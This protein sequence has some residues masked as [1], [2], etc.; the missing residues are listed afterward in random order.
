MHEALKLIPSYEAQMLPCRFLQGMKRHISISR[1]FDLWSILSLLE[2]L[3]NKERGSGHPTQSRHGD[4]I[5]STRSALKG[6][7][8]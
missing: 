4:T 3:K 1:P 2:K 5:I 6:G 7:G 8:F